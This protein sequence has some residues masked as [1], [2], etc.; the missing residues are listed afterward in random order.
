MRLTRNT[1]WLIP[2]AIILTFPLWSIPV[3]KF[4][5]PR[6][7]FDEDSGAGRE[8]THNF[9]MKQIKILQ[10]QK[11]AKTAVIVADQA[12]TD[13]NP[14]ILLM[15]TVNADIYD[16][17]GDITNIVA[18]SGHY[19]LATKTLIL[20]KNVV[21]KKT[22]ENQILYTDL[23]IYNNADR[24]VSCPGPTRLEAENVQIDGGSLEYD[25]KTQ[26]YVIDNRVHC[27]IDGFLK[28]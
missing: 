11:G 14:D 5:T 1:I 4:L 21:V 19:D 20:K 25:I 13:D 10:N 22:A 2:L 24:R 9:N 15:D 6:G 26:S 17:K 12:R 16:E 8:N 18:D 27:I 28:P 23:L 7:G 3:G